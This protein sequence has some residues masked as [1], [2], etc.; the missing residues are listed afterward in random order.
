[1]IPVIKTNYMPHHDVHE[2]KGFFGT[3][4]SRP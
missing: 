4:R 3:L 1:M 2:R